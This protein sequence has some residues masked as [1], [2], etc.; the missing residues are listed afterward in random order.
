VLRHTG[1][2][3]ANQKSLGSTALEVILKF[4]VSALFENHSSFKH[5]KKTQKSSYLN[6]AFK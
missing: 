4:A 2:N 3:A 1:E 5:T 6:E